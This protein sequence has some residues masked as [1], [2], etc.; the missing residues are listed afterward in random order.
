MEAV[1]RAPTAP[2]LTALARPEMAP[3]TLPR[4]NN[5]ACLLRLRHR[6]RRRHRATLG[7]RVPTA[8]PVLTV[9]VPTVRGLRV[10]RG[11]RAVIRT[12]RRS[13]LPTPTNRP[14]GTKGTGKKLPPP[15][16]N[17]PATPIPMART[18]A[19]SRLGFRPLPGMTGRRCE[20]VSPVPTTRSAMP[21]PR[22][23]GNAPR[24]PRKLPPPN[25]P[26]AATMAAGF[27][28][29]RTAVKGPISPRLQQSEG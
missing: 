17:I 1:H 7:A 15:T 28:S 13:P 27:R 9:R 16:A 8:V 25:R 21:R 19:R 26:N 29:I 12:C 6:A 22:R 20:S 18:L 2:V 24:H 3:G 23:V 5:P 4:S 11:H 14:R 10:T